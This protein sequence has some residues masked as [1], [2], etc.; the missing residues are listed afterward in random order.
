MCLEYRGCDRPAQ[1]LVTPEMLGAGVTAYNKWDV[2]KEEIA[3]EF[4]LAT[5]A[6]EIYLAMERARGDVSLDIPTTASITPNL[7]RGPETGVVDRRR[8]PWQVSSSG[9]PDQISWRKRRDSNPRK[10]R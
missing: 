6:D 5:L 7:A 3:E 4:R 8:S 1:I 10:V 9:N 2:R